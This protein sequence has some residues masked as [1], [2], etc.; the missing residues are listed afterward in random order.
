MR[1]CPYCSSLY[2]GDF[3][4]CAVDG[5]RLDIVH[6]DRDPLLGRAVDR[7]RIEALLGTGST[8]RVYRAVHRTREAELALKVIWGDLGSDQRLVRRFQRGAS[9]THRVHHPN[10]VRILD[11]GTT[12]GGLSFLV[13]ELVRGKSMQEVVA[14]RGPLAPLLTAHIGLQVAR[15]LGAAHRAGFVHRDIKPANLVLDGPVEAPLVKILDFGLVGLATADADARITASGSFVGTPLYM[16]PEQARNASDVGP[17]ADVYSLGVVL[18]E[19]LT[20]QAPFRGTTPLEVMIAHSTL[21]PP[22]PP[23]SGGIGPLVTAMLE[24]IPERRPDVAA[25][26]SELTRCIDHLASGAAPARRRL[27]GPETDPMPGL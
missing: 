18:Y 7:Y 23:T 6:G 19:L 9:A 14:E 20:G 4:H 12:I 8:G 15:G 25:V 16:A 27:Q 24:K 10:V 2:R 11:F 5:T 1:F 21:P 3:E 13:M 26:K 22:R 17:A